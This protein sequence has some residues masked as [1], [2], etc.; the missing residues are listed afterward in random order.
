MAQLSAEA[1]T[2]VNLLAGLTQPH[3]ESIRQ[4][5]LNLKPTLKDPR[6]VPALV[7]VLKAHLKQQYLRFYVSAFIR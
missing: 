4:A 3:T 1:V 2:M 7:E 6:C 5:E